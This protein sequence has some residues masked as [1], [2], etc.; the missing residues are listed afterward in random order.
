MIPRRIPP[1]LL[2][3]A[4]NAWPPLLGA[5]IRVR[6]IASDFRQFDVELRP[7]WYNRNAFGTHFGGSLFVM[8][9]PFFALML[10]RNLPPGYLVWDRAASVE[11]VSPGRT[12]VVARMRLTEEDI[13]MILRMTANGDKHLHLFK[14]EVRDADDLL[15]ARAERIVYVRRRRESSPDFQGPGSA[16]N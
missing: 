8:T 14:V 6:R 7:R 10:V 3:L 9:D 2:R 16:A 13:A 11:F 12:E 4:L 1:W 15:V 5:G